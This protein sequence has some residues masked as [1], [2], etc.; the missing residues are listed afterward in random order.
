[1]TP[2][3]QGVASAPRNPLKA[4]RWR[5]ITGVV[6]KTIDGGA[7]WS[8]IVIDSSLSITTGASPSSVVCWLAGKAGAVLRSTDGGKTF[9][10]VTTPATADLVS[11]TAADGL[12]ATVA[13]SDGRRLTTTDGG[14]TWTR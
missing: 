6:E 1:L 7:S 11:I 12:T 10:R 14:Q 9:V 13:T 2:T 3:R 5:V 8:R 4:I